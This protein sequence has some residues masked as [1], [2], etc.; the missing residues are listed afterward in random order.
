[1]KTRRS[2]A[3]S[4]G[5]RIRIR[6]V[7]LFVRVVGQGPPLVLMHGGPGGDH[8][9]LWPFRRLADRFT[10]VFYDHRCN[11]RSTG[12]PVSTMTWQNLTADVDALRR[13]LGF[14]RWAVLGHSFGG[15][16][17]LE[18]V[19]RYPGSVSHLV[20]LDTGGDHWWSQENGPAL[21]ARRG[22]SREKV[23][24]ARRWFAGRIPPKVSSY[25]LSLMKLGPAYNPHTGLRSA[26]REMREEWRSKLSPEAHIFCF[27]E[28]LPGWTV[29][30]RLGDIA[31]PTLVMAGR[32][33]FVYPPESQGQLAAAI[34]NAR[35]RIIER[36]GHNPHS[37]QPDEVMV[38]VAEFL[39]SAVAVPAASTG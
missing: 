22:Y 38:A 1:M 31:V 14:D 34:P 32:D 2:D 24:L 23:E 3:L 7:D 5:T 16:V 33:D 13:L 30:D 9:T 15:N 29:M 6:D 27:T 26:L 18:Y 25:F 21:L 28:L 35:L 4:R 19:L 10:L 17:A 37:E 12:A 36:A 11:G 8:W 39:T 20:L